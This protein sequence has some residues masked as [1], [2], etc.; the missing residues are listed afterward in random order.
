MKTVEETWQIID[1]DIGALA[2]LRLDL[3]EATVLRENVLARHDL[4]RFDRSAVDGF[5]FHL[6]DAP[7][8]RVPVSRSLSPGDPPRAPEPGTAIRIATGAAVPAGPY[9]IVKREDVLRHE[10][11]TI[12]PGVQPAAEW[13]RRAGSQMRTGD[14]LLPAGSR[15]NAAATALL[16]SAGVSSVL[17]AP[18]PSVGHIAT[19]SEISRTGEEIPPWGISDANSPMIASLLARHGARLDSWHLIPE[20]HRA[21]TALLKRD[22]PLQIV[23]GGAGGGEADVTLQSLRDAGFEPLVTGVSVRPGKPF[24]LARR[25]RSVAVGLPGNPLSHFIC[26]QIFVRRILDR[27]VG[28]RPNQLVSVNVPAGRRPPAD[29]RE[30]WWPAGWNVTPDGIS[31]EPLPWTDSSDLTHLPRANALLRVPAG[32][33]STPAA[34]VLLL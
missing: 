28:A 2:P 17:G 25:G 15:L 4:P 10:D 12:T 9:G 16:A 30:T 19:G 7:G 14:V 18:V 13:I 24:L 22:L 34:E 32:G 33:L 1:R 27:L 8:A 3:A 11:G 6:N 20:D 26:F 31:L 21:L 29:E 5:L 23:S